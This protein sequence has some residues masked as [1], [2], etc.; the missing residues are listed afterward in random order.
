MLDLKWIR[1]NPEQFRKGIEAKNTRFDLDKLFDQLPVPAIE[2]LFDRDPLCIQP[3][4]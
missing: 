4:A 1:E 3:E 2:I